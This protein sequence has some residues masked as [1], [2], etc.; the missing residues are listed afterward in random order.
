MGEGDEASALR[1]RIA[2]CSRSRRAG[3]GVERDRERSIPRL[4]GSAGQGRCLRHPRHRQRPGGG[5]RRGLERRRRIAASVPRPSGALRRYRL[6]RQWRS[7]LVGV[8]DD[9]QARFGSREARRQRPC[10]GLAVQETGSR[11]LDDARGSR[12]RQPRWRVGGQRGCLARGCWRCAE[13]DSQGDVPDGERLRGN[14]PR[15]AR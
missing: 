14:V 15:Q 9:E 5:S 4:E 11:Y 13:G 2:P 1:P 7:L 6:R 10:L 8:P 3:D 12:V